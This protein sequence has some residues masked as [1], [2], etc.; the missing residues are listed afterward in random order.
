LKPCV[1]AMPLH[2]KFQIQTTTSAMLKNHSYFTND[3]IVFILKFHNQ[4]LCCSN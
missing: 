1:K 3:F 4:G 2:K